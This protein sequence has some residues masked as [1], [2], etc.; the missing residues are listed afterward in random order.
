MCG[1]AGYYGF[2]GQIIRENFE[3]MVDIVEYRGPDS[4]G[5]FFKDGVALGHRRLSIIDL[6]EDG[7]QP[8]FYAER[9]VLVYNGEIYNYKELKQE[10]IVKDYQFHTETDTEVLAAA[11]DYWG[12]ECVQHFNGMW[13]FAILDQ[14]NKELFCSRDR[15]GVK[16]FY[17]YLDSKQFIF[18]SE[19]KQ[20]LCMLDKPPVANKKR[21][22]EFLVCGDQDYTAETMFQ[23]ILQLRGGQEIT[24]DLTTKK[25]KVDEYYNLGEKAIKSESYEE[26]CGNFRK[27]FEN[28]I[29]L[30]LRADVPVGYCLSGGLDSSSIVCVANEQVKRSEREIEQHTVS[31]CFE[32]KTYDEQEYIDEVVKKT[33]VYSHKI[34]PDGSTLFDEMDKIIWHMDEPFGSTSVYAQWNVFREAKKNNLTVMLD[35][36]GAD[37]QLAGYSSFYGVYFAQLLR[38]LRFITF[39]RELKSYKK[40]RAS[41]EKH[42]K[43]KKILLSAIVAAYLPQGIYMKL[44][45]KFQHSVE[46]PFTAEQVEMV[47]KNRKIYSMGDSKQFILDNMQCG[48]QSLLHFEDRNSMAFSIESR[49]PFLDYKL[50]ETI[51][52]IPL[53]YKIRNG[54][55]K[56]VLRDGLKGILPEKIRSRY[57]KLGFV[58]PEDKWINEHYDQYSKELESACDVLEPLVDKQWV[59][60]WFEKN[61]GKIAR[62]DFT[63]WRIICAGRW[64][65]IFQ[66]SMES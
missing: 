22:L 32:D 7:C 43:S 3:K 51:M 39:W 26:S 4:R 16:P 11:Y 8:F 47:Y 59:M 24:F 44:R 41:T 46:L 19:I 28:S 33:E 52:G 21:L 18:A 31:S 12:K 2:N 37:E 36:Q 27:T 49:V 48:M 14:K 53:R 56:A 50:V 25:L 38:Q 5:T 40:L 45:K 10:L 63:V 13:S 17:Y 9:Y 58:T 65:R 42:V 6:S 61:C 34:Y 60:E 29:K 1:I 54:I 57:S 66:V 55:T 20:I 15:F 23:G 62:G 64:A 30:R 35:G